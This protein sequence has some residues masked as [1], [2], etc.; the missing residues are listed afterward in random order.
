M[1]STVSDEQLLINKTKISLH[2]L[3]THPCMQSFQILPQGQP[4]NWLPVIEDNL[5]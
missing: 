3:L 4:Y 5:G 1:L 2:T